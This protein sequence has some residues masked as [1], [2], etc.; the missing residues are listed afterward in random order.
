[1]FHVSPLY[2]KYG[3]AECIAICGITRSD[4]NAFTTST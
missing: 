2:N 4:S 1:L 3:Y